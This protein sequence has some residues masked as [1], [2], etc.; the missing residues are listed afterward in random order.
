[1]ELFLDNDIILKLSSANLLEK[2][3]T[4]FNSTS[5]SIYILPTAKSYISKSK[6][7]LTKY[8]QTTIKEALKII[9]NYQTI[10]DSYVDQ[11]KFIKLSKIEGI[12]SGEQLLYSLTPSSEDFLILTGDKVSI[13]ALNESS[14]ISSI[15]RYFKNK[16]V[17]LEQIL[18]NLIR[19]EGFID[20]KN[21]IEKSNFCGDD[22]TIKICFNQ[23]DAVESDV[24]NCLDSYISDLK[25]QAPNLF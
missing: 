6:R 8:R 2:I 17:C 10:P 25:K 20:I 3:E 14:V 19:S 18:I 1:M 12:D 15:Q 16:I 4:I 11:N 24:T 22:K 13:T 21:N 7:V 23:T 9:S 5:S